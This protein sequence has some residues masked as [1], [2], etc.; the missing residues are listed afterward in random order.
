[1]KY[2]RFPLHAG[3]M[4]TDAMIVGAISKLVNGIPCMTYSICAT[5]PLTTANDLDDYTDN[6]LDD[7]TYTLLEI[8][9]MLNIWRGLQLGG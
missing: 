4:S 6:D 9:P 8:L 1:M 2:I 7:Y 3:I 5:R